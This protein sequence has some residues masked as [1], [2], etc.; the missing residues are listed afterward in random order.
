MKLPELAVRNHQFTWV[1]CSLLLMLGVVSFFTMPRS[2]DPQFD[3][4]A[5]VIKVVN[6]GTTPLDME[7]LVVDP[8]ES[9]IN[10]LD[11]LREIKT[12]VE[13][14]LAVIRVE[15]LYGTDPEDK[16][17]DVVAAVTRVRDRLPDNIVTLDI[18]KISPADVSILQLALV[19][20]ARDYQELKKHAETLEQKLERVAGVKRVD[21]AALP[22][23]EVQIQVDQR[24]VNGLGISLDEIY[25][26]V[27]SAAENL[28][29]GHANAGER[30]FTVRTSGD[31][32]SL[33]A[34]GAT[35]VRA[36]DSRLIYLSDIARISLTESLPSYR[37]HLNG[38]KAVFLSVVQ[39]KG[40]QIFRVREGIEQVLS[41]YRDARLP[42]DVQMQTV[43]DQS[44]SVERQIDGFF[45]NLNQGLVLV[46]VLSLVVLGFRPALV[47]VAAIPLSIFIA[48][49]W[50]DMT[51][52]GLQQMS[53]VGLVIALGLLVD[54][55]IV[56][57]ENVARHLRDGD[58]PQQ[59]AIT[60]S[61][62]V[63]W[64]VASGTITTVLSFLPML[65]MQNGSGTFMRAMPV[66]VVLTLFASLLVALTLTPLLA[67]KL[68][69]SAKQ[70][71]RSQK[72]LEAIASG[73]YLDWLNKALNKP[74]RVLGISLTLLLASMML[75]PVIGVSLFPKA[76]KPMLL[77]NVDMPEGTTFDKTN[78]MAARV[79]ALVREEPLVID[80]ARNVGRGN[81]RIYYN[82][83]PSRQTV[84]FA[85][86]FVT[87]S[88]SELDQ[89][90]PLV[91]RL[92]EHL[93]GF[94]GAQITVKEFMQGP[95][96][97]A[98]VEIRVIGEDLNDIQRVSRDV[99]NIMA[100]VPG[101]VG[102]EN[103]VGKYKVD[104]HVQINRDKAAMLGVPLTTI[105]R[106][107]RT[108]LVGL[109]M[110]VYRDNEG[111]EYDLVLRLSEYPRPEL[112]TFDDI[113]VM[114]AQGD[115]V[116]LLQL[117]S[118]EMETS[119][120][121]FQH[122]DTERMARITSDVLPGFTTEAVTNAVVEELQM[123]QWPDGV[124]F[125]VGGEQA[126]RKKAFGGMAK[127]LILAVF[128]IF[129]VLVLQ[130]RS[131]IQP[132][133]VFAAIPF[134]L[135]GALLALFITG[136]TFSFTAFIGLTSLIGIVVNNSIILVDYA[137][138][139]RREGMEQLQAIAAAAQTRFVPIVLTTLTTIGGLLPLTLSG[140][141]MWSPMGWAIIGGLLVSTLLTLI[142]VPVLYR[143]LGR[144]PD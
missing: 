47:V 91:A 104:L 35:V 101:V 69:N 78:A 144:M 11:D 122:F 71:T 39:R 73:F 55:A 46:A 15:F 31:Y 113:Q 137:N 77:V 5:A 36:V 112:A 87:L 59:A 90:E 96:V 128:G 79:E 130:F 1:V 60:G 52:F 24:K 57:V 81:P 18:D 66:T 97:E 109:P 115:L 16:Y 114:S 21:I 140:S 68:G 126:N 105:D 38:E 63:A 17:D 29:G 20:S 8:L 67:S 103:P 34:V 48:I 80:I 14:G 4:S 28:P 139:M 64:A 106:T 88:A 56:V 27:R 133:I 83:M 134:A 9:A 121:R 100:Q 62:Q 61:S 19:S 111:E 124:H 51:G 30:R 25:A 93:A 33:D 117:A 119:I 136:Y 89:V 127:A 13:D 99:E 132:L 74:R 10:E 129:A 43:M 22:T 125:K 86:L 84:N 32:E 95:P 12:E 94:A 58:C 141:S 75:F 54:N 45:D 92:R 131:F 44:V 26:A 138:Q 85:Q 37:A 65:L 118:V 50:L 6:P 135:I 102:V 120:A 142:V 76:E 23:L 2:E 7:K 42:D 123:Y 3:F 82:I 40:S 107:I 72:K 98:P 108:A 53:I 143:F 49:G 116:P 41:D 70:T 110:G